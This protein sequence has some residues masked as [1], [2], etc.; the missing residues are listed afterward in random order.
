MHVL[1]IMPIMQIMHV[2]RAL[3]RLYV[4]ANLCCKKL[5][6]LKWGL[7]VLFRIDVLESKA[8]HVLPEVARAPST[9]HKWAIPLCRRMSHQPLS[10]LHHQ[11][12][13]EA[14]VGMLQDD[15]SSSGWAKSK[16]R[17]MLHIINY[18][19]TKSIMH[20]TS[21]SIMQ[22]KHTLM[23]ICTS[24]CQRR[25]KGHLSARIHIELLCHTLLESA[26]QVVAISINGCNMPLSLIPGQ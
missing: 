25:C 26:T 18:Q 21:M 1:H 9:L 13:L 4:H 10:A 5:V 20:I 3:G 12:Y 19:H 11:G 7:G 22:I 17:T 24:L 2:L 14:A 16:H 6:H 15:S 8:N 23:R